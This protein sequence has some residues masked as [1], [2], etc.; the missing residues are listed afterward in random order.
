[1]FVYETDNMY[2]CINEN[3]TVHH[4]LWQKKRRK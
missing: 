3:A 2:I 4:S 1:M